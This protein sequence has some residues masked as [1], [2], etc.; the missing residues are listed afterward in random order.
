MAGVGSRVAQGVPEPLACSVG[1]L[2]VT[3]QGLTLDGTCTTQTMANV[4][5]TDTALVI[6]ALGPRGS[7]K[8]YQAALNRAV[9]LEDLA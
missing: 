5:L 6:A 3:P 7:D 8:L 1:G 4:A 9:E 2:A